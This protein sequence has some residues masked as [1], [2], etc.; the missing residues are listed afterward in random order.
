M[1]F[2]KIKQYYKSGIWN[3]KMVENA[4]EKGKITPQEYGIIVGKAYQG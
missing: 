4:V 3:Q 2:E 1:W